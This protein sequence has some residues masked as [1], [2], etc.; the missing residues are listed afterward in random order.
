MSPDLFCSHM[1][2]SPLILNY[3]SWILTGYG[4][5][6]IDLKIVYV[7][8][9]YQNVAVVPL[10]GTNMESPMQNGIDKRRTLE[11]C[12]WRHLSKKVPWRTL[13][14]F[15]GRKNKALATIVLSLDPGLLYVVGA[16]P[17]IPLS[18]GRFWLTSSNGK[19]GPTN[20]NWSGSC[21]QW[22]W[23]KEGQYKPMS[24]QWLNFVMNCRWLENQ[25]RKKIA[26]CI[27]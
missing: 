2:F 22:D 9:P 8:A 10:K 24:K 6:S 21:S 7:Y 26:S 11:Y 20:W 14:K 5:S 12:R 23:P 19:H 16:D 27:F 1:Y 13:A 15:V 4:P 25:L 3:Q 17:R 18:Y